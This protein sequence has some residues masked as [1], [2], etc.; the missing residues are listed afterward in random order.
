MRTV[1]IEYL[2]SYLIILVSLNVAA[3]LAIFLI[4]ELT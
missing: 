3:R 1:F 4:R 2:M